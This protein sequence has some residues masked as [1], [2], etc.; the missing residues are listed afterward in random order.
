MI[1][2]NVLE[3]VNS[4]TFALIRAD[5]G[6]HRP[7]RTLEIPRNLVRIEGPQSYVGMISVDDQGLPGPGDREGRGQ[8]MRLAGQGGQG[9][10]R[11]DEIGGLMKDAPVER[12][13]LIGAD[14]IGVRTRGAD[15]ERLGPRQLQGQIFQRAPVRQISIFDRA[16]VD[17]RR[18]ALGLQSRR[19]QKPAA[20]LAAR[21][22]NQG[23]CGAPQRGQRERIHEPSAVRDEFQT[24]FAIKI[25]HRSGR[26]FDRATRHVDRGPATLREQASRRGNLLGD[27]DTVDIIGL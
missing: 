2:F 27:R 4:E 18:H 25:K 5:G 24:V 23:F 17:S 6:Q 3:Q 20:A 12:K 15:C 1:A 16:L 8:A 13:R 19:R 26:F 22:Q 11:L 7:P 9:L 10:R 21:G 14:A